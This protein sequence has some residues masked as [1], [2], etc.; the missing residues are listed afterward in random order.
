M[1]TGIKSAFS[2]V[3]EE[4]DQ[5]L[6]TI[7]GNTNEIQSC[8]EYLAELDAK[9]EKLSERLDDLQFKLEPEQEEYFDISLSHRE[10]EVFMVLYV[11]EDPITTS[12]VA[13]RLGMS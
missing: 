6:D 13:K 8:Y 4:M 11:R 2:K 7:N 10:Q 3:K 5:H 12:E 9:M 1:N